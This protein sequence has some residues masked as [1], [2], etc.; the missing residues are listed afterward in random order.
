LRDNTTKDRRRRRNIILAITAS[1]VEIEVFLV[2]FG[3]GLT[4]IPGSA[5]H[6]EKEHK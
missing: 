1:N 6:R 2:V 4:L 3:M 5:R